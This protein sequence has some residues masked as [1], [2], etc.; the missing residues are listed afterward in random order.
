MKAICEG[1]ANRNDVVQ[2]SVGKYREMFAQ[3][4]Q[5]I[6][7]LKAVSSSTTFCMA[8]SLTGWGT[9]MQTLCSW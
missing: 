2:E 8:F 4:V 9:V 5:H 1:R 7:V 6:D 3:T